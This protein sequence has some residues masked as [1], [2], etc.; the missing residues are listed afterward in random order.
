MVHVFYTSYTLHKSQLCFVEILETLLSFY[1]KMHWKHSFWQSDY[2][3]S[4]YESEV[5]DN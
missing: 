3:R 4:W 1:N 5:L 2:L